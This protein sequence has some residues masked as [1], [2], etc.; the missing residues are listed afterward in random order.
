MCPQTYSASVTP[1][2]HQDCP[3][4][5]PAGSGNPGSGAHGRCVQCSSGTPYNEPRSG[6][7]RPSTFSSYQHGSPMEAKS[8]FTCPCPLKH[9]PPL[10]WE[11]PLP[12]RG[13]PGGLSQPPWEAGAGPGRLPASV[14]SSA[15]LQAPKPGHS[16]QST[17]HSTR[18]AF[19]PIPK[20]G[21][22]VP[23]HQQSPAGT[24]AALSGLFLKAMWALRRQA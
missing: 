1:I 11:T 4:A 8:R 19:E 3:R 21:E 14:T 23:W 12:S 9:L 17:I 2:R 15:P 22:K 24:E 13:L 20:E 7:E 6:V 16:T 18:P 5:L 10:Q